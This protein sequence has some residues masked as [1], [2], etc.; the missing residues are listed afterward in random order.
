MSTW[1][2][3]SDQVVDQRREL[4]AGDG[5]LSEVNRELNVFGAHVQDRVALFVSDVEGELRVG[6]GDDHG[7]LLS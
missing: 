5:C 1:V 7:V 3:C 4:V 2:T 6:V